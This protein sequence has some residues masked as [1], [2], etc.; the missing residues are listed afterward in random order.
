MYLFIKTLSLPMSDL[1]FIPGVDYRLA[2][3][4][5]LE[6]EP[7]V[8]NSYQA[9]RYM[10]IP[11]DSKRWAQNGGVPRAGDPWRFSLIPNTSPVVLQEAFVY[12]Q[13][14]VVRS[15][16]GAAPADPAAVGDVALAF[17]NGFPLFERG[18]QY[19]NGTPVEQTSN[20]RPLAKHVR[21]LLSYSSDKA[22]ASD[23]SNG[24]WSLD[25]N[26]A[27][28]DPQPIILA[29]VGVAA[30]AQIAADKVVMRPNPAFNK[31]FADRL[32]YD[33]RKTTDA[34]TTVAAALDKITAAGSAVPFA[35]RLP[36]REEFDNL[37]T[38]DKG[39]I[40]DSS[41][42]IEMF[43]SNKIAQLFHATGALENLVSISLTDVNLIIPSYVLQSTAKERYMSQLQGGKV[44]SYNFER[45]TV[46]KVPFST[47]ASS[48]TIPIPTRNETV[49]RVIVVFRQTAQENNLDLT[50]N[51]CRFANPCVLD[52]VANPWN[53]DAD[54]TTGTTDFRVSSL[55]LT[56][57]D[58]LVPSTAFMPVLRGMGELYS[59]YLDSCVRNGD[60]DSSPVL[61]YDDFVKGAFMACFDCRHLSQMAAGPQTMMLT[62]TT[63]GTLPTGANASFAMYAIV[64][65]EATV[66]YVGE[67]G[68]L[69]PK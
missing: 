43:V 67:N 38:F 15:S 11:E 2:D 62:Y 31:G 69:I 58:A 26:Y 37:T 5:Q 60:S 49:S 53:N 66:K 16:T 23:L 50:N 7:I 45:F 54:L 68:T 20:D 21:K 6:E 4:L 44:Y 48:Q 28:A 63:T 32:L 22:Q 39:I 13:G 10:T 41:V 61:S 51:W 56:V 34:A 42:V 46:N 19:G 55:Q 40:A 1:D 3:A 65:T 17:S 35:I 64:C 57:G 36:L 24:N 18:T 30:T 47:W 12:L 9:K 8:D 25:R 29:G 59:A 33:N 27:T 14:I 52:P